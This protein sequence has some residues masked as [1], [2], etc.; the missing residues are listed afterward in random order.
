MK[1]LDFGK[2]TEVAQFRDNLQR[3]V[4]KIWKGQQGVW[5]PDSGYILPKEIEAICFVDFD[6]DAKGEDKELYSDLIYGGSVERNLVFYPHGSA[7][8]MDAIQLKHI[9]LEK[10]TADNN[11][12]CIANKNGRVKLTIRLDY[13]ETLVTING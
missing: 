6:K 10:M 12:Y 1:F 8:G 13:G 3:D 4:D 9:D 2:L 11:P 7:E 5:S